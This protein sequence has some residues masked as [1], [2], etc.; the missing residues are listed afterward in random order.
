MSRSAEGPFLQMT[1]AMSDWWNLVGFVGLGAETDIKAMMTK[2]K[3][4]SVILLYF[5]GQIFK[6]VPLM[7]QQCAHTH[8]VSPVLFFRSEF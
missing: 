2:V 5:I 4:G 6:C 3:G 1:E 7:L 8:G